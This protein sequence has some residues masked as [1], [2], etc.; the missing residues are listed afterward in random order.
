MAFYVVW[1]SVSFCAISPYVCLNYIY[2]GFGILSRPPFG[3]ELLTRLIACS[4]CI[5]SIY[6]F[7]CVSF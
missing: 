1:F 7:G 4:F 5:M 2:L 3:K 6:K